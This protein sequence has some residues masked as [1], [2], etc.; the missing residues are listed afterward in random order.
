M[1]APAAQSILPN[2]AGIPASPAAAQMP[3]HVQIIQ[4]AI[5]I[6]AS[7]AIYAAAKLGIPDLLADGPLGAAELAAKCGAHP[8]S[9]HRLLRTLASRGVFTE[10]DPARFALTPLGAA[11][12]TG[13]PGAAR[14]AVL[15]LAGDWQWA[16]WGEFMHSVNT[17]ESGMRKAWENPLFAYLA[18]HPEDGALFNEAMVAM[19]AG[20]AAAIVTAYDFSGMKKLADLGGGTGALI[21]TILRAN[22][23]LN[24]ILLD[25]PQTAGEAAENLATAGVAN[26]CTFVAGDLFKDVPAG[27]DGYI[28]SHVLHDWNDDESLA[29]LRCCRRAMGPQARLLI[30]ETVLPQGDTPHHGKMLDMLMLTVTGGIER[31]AEE[32]ERLLATASLKLT[33]I[34][35]TTTYQSIVEAV[36]A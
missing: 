25:L 31:T 2:A 4:M 7:R 3:P 1:N 30:V 27:C 34:V 29:I 10:V 23:K 19:H 9:L 33:R 32:Y 12:K 21:C 5:A 15:T 6:W 22:V 35:P 13:A 8:R 18:N 17:G 20:E 11:L 16:A 28:L 24:G 36:P 26:R 14:A